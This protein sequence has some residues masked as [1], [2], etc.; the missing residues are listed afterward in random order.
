[1]MINIRQTGCGGSYI[2]IS[3]TPKRDL[4]LNAWAI[5]EKLRMISMISLHNKQA[6]RWAPEASFRFRHFV[7]TR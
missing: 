4:H 2:P 3:A 5:F 7:S 6:V 1:M